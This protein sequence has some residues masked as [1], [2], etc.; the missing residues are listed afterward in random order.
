M[1]SD[2][3]DEHDSNYT[4][5]NVL[6]GYTSK[7]EPEEDSISRLGGTPSWMT[8]DSRPSA[9]MARCKVCGDL[10]V[11]LLQLNGELPNT[12][13]GHER[14]LYIFTCRRKPCRRKEGCVRALRAVKRIDAPSKSKKKPTILDSPSSKPPQANIGASLFEAFASEG[15]ADNANPFTTSSGSSEGL[16]SPFFTQK[17]PPPQGPTGP[18]KGGD[19]LA[20]TFAQKVAISHTSKAEDAKE[21]VK[22]D[23]WPSQDRFPKP[24]TLY[25]LDADYESLDQSQEPPPTDQ[26]FFVDS[27]VSANEKTE[28]GKEKEV[29]ESSLDKAFQ[30]FAD[31]IAQNPTQVLRY[32]FG[33]SPLLYSHADPIGRLFHQCNRNPGKIQTTAS[34]SSRI[35]RCSNCQSPRTFELQLTPNAIMELEAEEAGL[36]GMDWGTILLGVCSRDCTIDEVHSDQVSFVEEW[37]GVQWEE[38]NSKR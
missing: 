37:V 30:K 9:Q 13:P 2:S 3:S 32:E 35:P 34:Q 27:D 4:E 36:D 14:R 6:L 23:P 21:T 19:G 26:K 1:D 12:F 38:L 28:N 7:I 20:Q 17:D 31:R 18:S 29:F 8:S 33:G 15:L 10:M 5:T 22:A 11:L 25:H 24:F 16:K